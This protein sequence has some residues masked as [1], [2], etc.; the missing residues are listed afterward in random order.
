MWSLY[1]RQDNY[2]SSLVTGQEWKE[3]INKE[4]KKLQDQILDIVGSLSMAFKHVS[5]W[6]ES[7]KDETGSITLSPTKVDGLNTCLAK[8]LT[9]L[10]SVNSQFKVQWRKQVL[11]KL[12]PQMSS[13]SHWNIL[14][15]RQKFV[16]SILWRKS[17]EKEW[18]SKDPFNCS[19]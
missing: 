3:L 8:V 13:I 15:S 12:N 10:G 4:S 19:F 11:D 1:L 9:L 17:E 7:G 5:S 18:N 16:W 14:W 2:L 6:Q